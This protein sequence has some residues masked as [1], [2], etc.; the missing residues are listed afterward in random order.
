[1]S[2]QGL[3]PLLECWCPWS[4]NRWATAPA[5]A[6]TDRADTGLRGMRVTVRPAETH[7]KEPPIP[8]PR[9]TRPCVDQGADGRP[10][11][12]PPVESRRCRRHA[13]IFRRDARRCGAPGCTSILDDP[14]RPLG[15]GF[16]RGRSLPGPLG[17]T[18]TY[19]R[20]CEHL[21]L[22]LTPE[23]E[24]ANVHEL[25]RQLVPAPSGLGWQW[26]GPTNAHGYGLMV[27]AGGTSRHQYLV[28]R[29]AFG[30]LAPIPGHRLTEQLDH[31][32]GDRLNVAPFNLEPVSRAENLRRRGRSPR[33]PLLR[34][35]SYRAALLAG[36]YGLPVPENFPTLLDLFGAPEPP[37]VTDGND[38]DVI[39]LQ[40][41]KPA[42]PASLVA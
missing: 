11:S 35:W 32:D 40:T 18:L 23:A 28:H 30:L 9:N 21:L 20:R 42:D 16:I 14:A 13:R 27:P 39:T 37:V 1:V 5:L 3:A 31:R 4:K 2:W 33:P 24:N 22:K 26:T 38:A 6:A 29:V 41:K 7:E 10:C 36:I 8:R 19:C 25:F 34:Q 15:S 12:G 17:S